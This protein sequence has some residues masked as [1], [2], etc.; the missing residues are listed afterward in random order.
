MLVPEQQGVMNAL[1]I[2]LAGAIVD[3][4]LGDYFRPGEYTLT[5]KVT[6]VVAAKTLEV[7]APFTLV[8]PAA[9]PAPA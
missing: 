8:A 7:K 6:D 4:N 2:D 5:L 1:V 3:V 9:P